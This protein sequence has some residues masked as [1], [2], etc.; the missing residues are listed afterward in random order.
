MV[1]LVELNSF[2]NEENYYRYLNNISNPDLIIIDDL[3]AERCSDYALERVYS[4]IEY[5]ISTGKP[6]IITTNLE[7]EE[8]KSATDIRKIRT[9]DRL[10]R[11]C[12]PIPFHGVSFRKKH[13]RDNFET[14]NEL[15]NA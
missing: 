13:A 11:V 12:F 7:L 5:R 8:I 10:F 6:M 2:L 15:L 9:Y 3:G 1:S 4:I 14:M